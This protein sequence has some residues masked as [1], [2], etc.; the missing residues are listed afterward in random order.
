M[1]AVAGAEVADHFAFAVDQDRGRVATYAVLLGG[2]APAA[3]LG[4]VGQL[5]GDQ[6][7]A[8]R[9]VA[10]LPR[11]L[12]AHF[13]LVVEFLRGVDVVFAVHMHTD[14]DEVVLELVVQV[15]QHRHAA[16]AWP[17]PVAPE[18]QHHVLALAVRNLDRATLPTQ[19]PVE[20]RGLVLDELE[21]VGRRNLDERGFIGRLILGHGEV[22]IDTADETAIDAA[23]VFAGWKQVH[24]F[25]G[26]VAG[27][28]EAC[29][30]WCVD[31]SVIAA[32][33]GT[34][35]QFSTLGLHLDGAD[36]LQVDRDF[37][38]KH[39][40]CRRDVGQAH[41]L[42][43]GGVAKQA[44]LAGKVVAVGKFQFAFVVQFFGMFSHLPL[45][46]CALG[47]GV[48]RVIAFVGSR[49]ADERADQ[50]I[51]HRAG[52]VLHPHAELLR[53]VLEVLRCLPESDETFVG[54]RVE[55]LR[56]WFCGIA[57]ESH[58]ECVAFQ[59]PDR[60][61]RGGGQL[62]VPWHA[63][64]VVGHH[65]NV[66][67]VGLLRVELKFTGKRHFDVQRFGQAELGAFDGELRVPDHAEV[68]VLAHHRLIGQPG[69]VE[70]RGLRGSQPATE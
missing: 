28:G 60:G 41:Q 57:R 39:D 12:D 51:G 15:E 48:L 30:R 65:G 25:A 42:S 8:E 70:L 43:L 37:R 44:T 6:G 10:A 56:P 68:A 20:F 45:R 69:A 55:R 67:L 19:H 21:E 53:V 16:D 27:V 1:L 34:P 40:G 38:V 24:E 33:L 4:V 66:Q 7:R 32:I 13:D 29:P 64:E 49:V 9:Q 31:V 17:T 14:D 59:F 5:A 46:F 54:G 3:V 22:Q 50:G 35:S 11:F 61:E 23:P 36:R 26:F 47:L 62:H 18:L 58:A 63:L 2:F 52:I